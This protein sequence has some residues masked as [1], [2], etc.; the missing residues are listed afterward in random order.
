MI[1]PGV[2]Y[3]LN[4]QNHKHPQLNHLI[5]HRGAIELTV[6]VAGEG[7][8]VINGV[9]ARDYRGYSVSC[10]GDFNGGGLAVLILVKKAEKRKAN[11]EPTD[12][13]TPRNKDLK[14]DRKKRTR[15]FQNS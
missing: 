3:R 12:P 2:I 7:G 1:Y 15:T 14:Y 4:R 11:D 5:H 9:S 13:E 8:F 6:I 10:A